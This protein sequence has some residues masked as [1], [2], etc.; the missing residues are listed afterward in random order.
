[1][2]KAI[3]EKTSSQSGAPEKALEVT[4]LA[5]TASVA[6]WLDLIEES[7]RFVTER[8]EQDVKTQQALFACRTPQ[9]LLKLQSDYCQKAIEQYTDQATRM[10]GKMSGAA[11]QTMGDMSATS[12]RKYDDVPL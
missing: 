1:M 7:T 6:A 11:T 2:T 9:D 12:A 8:W 3:H 10:S 4:Q 5:Q